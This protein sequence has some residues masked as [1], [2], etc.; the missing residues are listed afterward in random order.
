M[1]W[2]FCT[3][4]SEFILFHTFPHWHNSGHF[5]SLTPGKFQF[6]FRLVIFKLTLVNGGWGISNEIALRCMPLDITDDK[7]TLVQVMAWCRQATN[8][9]LSQ[10]WP[11]SLSPNGVTRP[12]WVNPLMASDTRFFCIKYIVCHNF[13]MKW[14]VGV[15]QIIMFY[16]NVHFVSGVQ[17]EKLFLSVVHWNRNIRCF[18]TGILIVYALNVSL[19]YTETWINAWS[20]AKKYI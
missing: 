12:Q 2:L 20:T 6:N 16:T 9:Y 14:I 19:L 13:N 15:Q 4:L 10:C 3:I 11:I 8:H 17:S 18:M 1:K 7:S 5:N